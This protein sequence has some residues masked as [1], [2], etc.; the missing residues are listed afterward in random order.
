MASTGRH[1]N[2]T[3]PR[4]SSRQRPADPIYYTSEVSSTQYQNTSSYDDQYDYTEQPSAQWER[5]PSAHLSELDSVEENQMGSQ[6]YQNEEYESMEQDNRLIKAP[7]GGHRDGRSQY[8]GGEQSQYDEVSFLVSR[9]V[10]S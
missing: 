2:S 1:R 7:R 3:Q 8:E 9:V 5:Q 6:Q 10:L 4:V